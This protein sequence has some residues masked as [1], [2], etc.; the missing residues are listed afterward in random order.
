MSDNASRRLGQR[1]PSRGSATNAA[2][3]APS[4]LTRRQSVNPT[5][6]PESPTESATVVGGADLVG[7]LL[8]VDPRTLIVGVNTRHD[9]QLDRYFVRDIADRGVREP[10]TVQRRGDGALVVRKG[11]RRTLAAVQ[12]GLPLVR[13]LLEPAPEPE[14]SDTA[15]RIECIID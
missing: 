1:I 11:Q 15:G 10:I 7:E 5:T 14:D 13:V 9:V 4:A 6:I 8:Q 12:A 3:R 2:G